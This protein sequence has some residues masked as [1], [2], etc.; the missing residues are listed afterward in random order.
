M[1]PIV[2][3]LGYIVVPLSYIFGLLN[4][5]FFILFLILAIAFGIFLSTTGIFLEELTYKRYPKWKHLFQLLLFGI[6]EN[7]GY[8]QINAFWRFQALL[9]FIFGRRRWEYVE[10]KSN[11]N[12]F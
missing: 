1:G 2:E 7:F 4:F 12:N 10:K 9:R 11:Q 5:K 6:L 3:L 8:R